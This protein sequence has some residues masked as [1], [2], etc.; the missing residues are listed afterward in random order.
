MLGFL[1]VVIGIVFVLLL[2]SLLATTLMELLA[3]GLSLRGKN[4]E[5][6]LRN[7]LASADPEER[8]LQDFKDNALYK[9]LSQHFR[10]RRYAPSYIPDES[11]Q[12]I[13]FEIILK[14]EAP[15]KMLEKIEELPD[16]DLRR[17]L[18]QFL[19][20]AEYELDAFKE[21]VR[22]WY[23]DVMDRA[24]GWYK[25][26]TQKILVAIGM[27]IA[28]IFNADTIAIYE[29]LESDPESLQQILE[30]AETYAGA[31]KESPIP[32]ATEEETVQQQMDK[33]RSLINNEINHAASPLGLGWDEANVEGLTAWGWSAKVLG[34]IVTAFA[35]TLGAPFWFDLLN[36]LVHLRNA[37]SKPQG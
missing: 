4:L 29:R 34:W 2:L 30:L 32:V 7:M 16:P 8:V 13:L 12:S 18:R 6:A 36:R 28:V 17:V 27:G 20:D 22:K 24:S 35:I 25:R 23:N 31:E 26:H 33:V 10:S 3:A 37:G 19:Q 5:N 1:E 15:E 14:G 9:Q 11:F 21:R